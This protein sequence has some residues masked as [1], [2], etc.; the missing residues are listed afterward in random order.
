MPFLPVF[1]PKNAFQNFCLL[2]GEK[3]TANVSEIRTALPR[4]EQ[5]SQEGPMRKQASPLSDR[6]PQPQPGALFAKVAVASC[7]RRAIIRFGRLSGPISSWLALCYPPGRPYSR[8]LAAASSPSTLDIR[9]KPPD[10]RSQLY[11]LIIGYRQSIFRDPFI[12]RT[13]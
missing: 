4:W 8:G 5:K 9:F 1:S 6:P 2:S 13:P 11:P 10:K 7:F 3:E 12:D